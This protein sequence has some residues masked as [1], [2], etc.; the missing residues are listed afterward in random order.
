MNRGIVSRP[1]SIAVDPASGKVFVSDTNNH[2]VLRYTGTAALTNGAD[3]EA[4]LGQSDFTSAVATTT[5]CSIRRRSSRPRESTC[6][7]LCAT[8]DAAQ[9]RGDM[10]GNR[11]C[12]P[13]RFLAHN[14]VYGYRFPS[15][16]PPTPSP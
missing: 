8:P 16:Q 14:L 12:T 15:P 2:R 7:W 4:M 5:C 6:R 11:P 9:Q 1:S 10:Q 13:P 3:A